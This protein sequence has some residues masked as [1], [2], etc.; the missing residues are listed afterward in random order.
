M[1]TCFSM[2]TSWSYRK[3]FRGFVCTCA[4]V[5][6]FIMKLCS[7]L[8][9]QFLQQFIRKYTYKIVT[10]QL[11]NYTFFY[12]IIKSKSIVEQHV[13][14]KKQSKIRETNRRLGSY[15]ALQNGTRQGVIQGVLWTG[16]LGLGENV[17]HY[18]EMWL[19][20]CRAHTISKMNCA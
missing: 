14:Q 17:Y 18:P 9:N 20:Q 12:C 6:A 13:T 4:V 7:T 10:C 16:W 1:K 8:S 15:K 19:N 2:E 5:T 3:C 11:K